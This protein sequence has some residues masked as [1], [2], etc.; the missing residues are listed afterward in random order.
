[1]KKD[2]KYL[3]VLGFGVLLAILMFSEIVPVFTVLHI[4]M[5]GASLALGVVF[6]RSGGEFRAWNPR[7]AIIFRRRLS[8]IVSVLFFL[9]AAVWPVG[10]LLRGSMDLADELLLAIQVM[11]IVIAGSMC[12]IP[13]DIKL[14]KKK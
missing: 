6:L 13:V 9:T 1:M 14:E 4:G 12:F 2:Y 5:T 10:A 11:G 3:A 8:Q 7:L